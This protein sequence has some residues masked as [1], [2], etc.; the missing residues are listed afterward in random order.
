MCINICSHLKL[1]CP[2]TQE[3]WTA[4][5]A[6]ALQCHAGAMKALLQAGA[7]VN[8]V[9]ASGAHGG[10]MGLSEAG[11]RAGVGCLN[12][13]STISILTRYSHKLHFLLLCKLERH[14][15]SSCLVRGS[16]PALVKIASS[17][18]RSKSKHKFMQARQF[19]LSALNCVGELTNRT[20]TLGLGCA[21]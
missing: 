11:L 15:A 19:Y 5:H 6:A 8:A 7:D 9:E 10:R 12:G 16:I 18:R 14:G 1:R 17:P 20:A 3:G 4:L 21:D 13:N 2:P